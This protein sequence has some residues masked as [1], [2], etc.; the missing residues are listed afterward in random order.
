[1]EIDAAGIGEE[2]VVVT[3][4]MMG[5]WYTM[6]LRSTL[7]TSWKKAQPYSSSFTPNAPQAAGLKTWYESF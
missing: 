5:D 3:K 1:M 6:H 2:K 7:K 4:A